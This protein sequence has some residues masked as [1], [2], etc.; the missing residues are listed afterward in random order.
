MSNRKVRFWLKSVAARKMGYIIPIVEDNGRFLTGQDLTYK[1]MVGEE[2]LTEQQSVKYPFVINPNVP[3]KIRHNVNID[4][5]NPEAKAI[6]KAALLSGRIA[7]SKVEYR[8]GIHDGYI[9]DPEVEA[10]AELKEFDMVAAAFDV[11]KE[12]KTEDLD[13]LTLLVSLQPGVTN[14]E[15]IHTDNQKL[16]A[17]YKT[18]QKTPAAILNSSTKHN[19]QVKEQLFIAYCIKH[20]LIVKKGANYVVREGSQETAY[21]GTTM[22]KAI[23]YL[24]AN[25]SLKD[26]LYTALKEVEPYYDVLI[27]DRVAASE[28]KCSLDQLRDKIAASIEDDLFTAGELMEEYKG[29]IGDTYTKDYVVLY[30]EVGKKKVMYETKEFEKEVAEK[31]LRSLNAHVYPPNS[32]FNKYKDRY[33][34]IEDI[35]G[36]RKLLV[37]LFEIEKNKKLESEIQAMMFD[38]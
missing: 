15:G 1:Q 25:A 17:L 32:M 24:D 38:E 9:I 28:D 34:E 14:M 6:I 11:I 2:P 8:D 10:N 22:V 26:R 21:L 3:H 7:A 23:A 4:P 37:E 36:K 27:S 31:D 13:I 20:K 29:R 18:A 12:T 30:R 5:D 19:P 35:D 16:S 33:K